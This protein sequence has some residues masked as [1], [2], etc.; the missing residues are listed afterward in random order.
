[1]LGASLNEVGLVALFVA[2]VLLASKAGKVGE[3]V[4]RMFDRE[5]EAPPPPPRGGDA[6]ER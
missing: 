3:A 2:L 1:M 6:G 4:G 5:D